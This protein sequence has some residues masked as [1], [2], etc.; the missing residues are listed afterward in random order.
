MSIFSVLNQSINNHYIIGVRFKFII[1]VILL[2]VS[3][4]SFGQ[5]KKSMRVITSVGDTIT[6]TQNVFE[7]FKS[8]EFPRYNYNN[9]WY[10]NNWYWS[11]YSFETG[12]LRS[13]SDFYRIQ[14]WAR[15]S[16]NGEVGT[17]TGGLNQSIINQERKDSYQPRRSFSNSSSRAYISGNNSPSSPTIKKQN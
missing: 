8:Q 14:E 12:A 1:I 9:N 3:T 11:N 6:V 15:R 5:K 4:N 7:F 2:F 17:L 16:M 10:W 13:P